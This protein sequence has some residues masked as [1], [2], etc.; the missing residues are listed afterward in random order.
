[1]KGVTSDSSPKASE[2]SAL[3]RGRAALAQHSWAEAFELLSAADRETELAPDELELLAQAAWWT[4][5]LP[6]AI[7][8]RE[9]AY[10]A[11][12]RAGR[13]DMAAMAAIALARDNTYR[14]ADSM[15]AAWLRRADDLLRDA[16]EGVAHGWLAAARAF[17]AALRGDID[18]AKA[19]ATR[20]EEVGRRT[21]S[22]ELTALAQAERGFALIN[23]GQV[24]E[25]LAL[26]DESS[27]A[28]VAG[29]LEPGTAGGICCT[30]IGACTNLG[31]WA[32]AAEWTEAQDRWCKRE[33]INGYPGMCRLYRSEIKQMRGQWLEAEAEARQASVELEGFIPAAAAAALYRIGAIRLQ[34]GD[35][36]AAEEALTRS[37]AIGGR[38]EPAMSLLRL[39]QG[40]T[41]VAAAAIRSALDEPTMEPAW[42]APPNAPL[43][44][45]PLLRAQIEIAL[46]AGD[47]DTAQRAL[48]EIET[49][50]ERFR[51]DAVR[52]SALAARGAVLLASGD[53]RAADAALRGAVEAWS[54]LDAP[55]EVARTRVLLARALESAGSRDGALLELRAAI[56]TFERLGAAL[57]LARARELRAALDGDDAEP[58]HGAAGERMIRTFVFTDIVDST[59]LGELLGDE[60]WGKLMRW[61]DQAVRTA[62]A[63]HGGEEV[64][65][66]GDGFFLAF[67]DA[68]RAIEAMIALQRRLVEQRDTQGFAP[69]I[70]VGVHAAE[71][72]R[73]AGDYTGM[74]VNVA[75]RI[76]A[77]AAGSEILV[78]RETLNGARRAFGTSDERALELKGVSEPIAV[79]AIAW[80]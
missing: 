39:A 73:V 6:M 74:G 16:P 10:A 4:G 35:L 63:E 36:E 59:K 19:Q 34:R 76:G 30:T 72:S 22:R 12:V 80:R 13:I 49:T 58:R 11:A 77:A 60:A 64:K 21:G 38:T 66:T 37:H 51:T 3:E 7:E 50:A 32:R 79:T 70:R 18:L 52:A 65:A 41:A 61:H 78:S 33:G 27:V 48:E 23:Q 62:V 15:G 9:R 71:A 29:E 53:H 75:A 57:D 42:D 56:T 1:M 47:L 2:P 40:R 45:L 14:S 68:D 5:R 44:R 25:G 17:H 46:A 31:E 20:A 28:A 67:D 55:H 24:E 26:V 69:A 54:K 8:V 43:S